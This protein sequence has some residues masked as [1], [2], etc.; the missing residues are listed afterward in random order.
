LSLVVWE[1]GAGLTQACGTGACAAV[2]AFTDAG[3][4]SPGDVVQVTLPGGPLEVCVAADGS[5]I[6][7]SGPAR[8]VFE[9]T[10]PMGS[11]N[12]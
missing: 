10:A 11:L 8:F 9:G 1:R 2:A 6:N 4:F 7:M 12:T 5:R 3:Y